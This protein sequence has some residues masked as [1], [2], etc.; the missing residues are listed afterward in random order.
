MG[1]TSSDAN[2]SP[3]LAANVA[4]GK[5]RDKRPKTSRSWGSFISSSFIEIEIVAAKALERKS[6]VSLVLDLIPLPCS[7]QVWPPHYSD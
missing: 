3:T 7:V 5:I 6:C 1:G 4:E 2:F